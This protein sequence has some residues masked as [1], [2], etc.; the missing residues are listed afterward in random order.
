MVLESDE[1]RI[2]PIGRIY[3]TWGQ[4]CSTGAAATALEPD[5]GWIN[6]IGWIYL[7]GLRYVRPG[8]AA[9]PLESD[10]KVQLGWI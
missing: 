4:M 1:A 6:P 9:K 8:L 10:E 5:G 2:N 3:P 7:M